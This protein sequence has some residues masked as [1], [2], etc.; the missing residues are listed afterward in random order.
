M[1]G[2]RVEEEWMDRS[3]EWHVCPVANEVIGLVLSTD[4]ACGIFKKRD[5]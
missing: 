2:E 3:E 1:L 4:E 5:K